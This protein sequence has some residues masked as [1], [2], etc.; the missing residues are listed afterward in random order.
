MRVSLAQA[1]EELTQMRDRLG[2]IEFES[3]IHGEIVE[4]YTE[5]CFA[6]ANFHVVLVERDSC[7][8]VLV[9]T[10]INRHY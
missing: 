10:T 7:S 3:I 6:T 9:V 1:I 8:P 5:R 4:E 2:D